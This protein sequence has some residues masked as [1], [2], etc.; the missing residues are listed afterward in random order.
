MN[1]IHYKTSVDGIAASM[2]I[3]FFEDWPNPPD[4]GT[5]LRILK[6]SSHIVLA[7]PQSDEKVVGYVTAISDGVT[8]AYIP[9]LEVL[10]EYRGQGIGSELVKRMIKQ[11][12]GIYAID[13]L[14]DEDVNPFYE[15]LGMQQANG[16]FIR[17]YQNQAGLPV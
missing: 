9:Q 17:N 7:L 14:C 11:L 4:S 1:N 2:L 6:G 3:G 16:M 5:H 13:L 12:N 15:R 10:P 8:C